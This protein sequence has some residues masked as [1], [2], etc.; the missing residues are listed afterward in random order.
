MAKSLREI[1]ACMLKL[2]VLVVATDGGL[3]GKN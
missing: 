2:G 1:N 3:E